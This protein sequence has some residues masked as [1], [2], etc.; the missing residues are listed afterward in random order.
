MRLSA[1]PCTDVRTTTV[2]TDARIVIKCAVSGTKSCV[3]TGCR[4][5]YETTRAK[6]VRAAISGHAGF[7]TRFRVGVSEVLENACL[8]L[9]SEFKA[10]C[11]QAYLSQARDDPATHGDGRQGNQCVRYKFAPKTSDA[12]VH[13]RADEF[14][15]RRAYEGRVK[16]A[17]LG[18]NMSLRQRVNLGRILL[19]CIR[20]TYMRHLPRGP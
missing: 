7:S 14:F 10:D 3:W 13:C 20:T 18:P 17:D 8:K 11:R 4:V 9:S 5:L 16:A 19:S 1:S 12:T 6:R 15:E 2:P